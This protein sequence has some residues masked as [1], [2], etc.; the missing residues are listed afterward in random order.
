MN[1]GRYA[2]MQKSRWMTYDR[3]E[4]HK[5]F[6]SLLRCRDAHLALQFLAAGFGRGGRG[7][8]EVLRGHAAGSGPVGMFGR[9]LP[10]RETH[11]TTLARKTLMRDLSE[12]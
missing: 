2:L 6:D 4:I 8:D 10:N 9:R 3:R 5:S 11:E 1:A 7:V 12:F